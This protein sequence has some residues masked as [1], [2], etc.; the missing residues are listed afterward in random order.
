MRI[1]PSLNPLGGYDDDERPTTEE[2]H[3]YLDELAR[4][5]KKMR[6]RRSLASFEK[7]VRDLDVS[8]RP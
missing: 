7:R 4:G 1:H 5:A 3:S 8:K 6:N 2:V